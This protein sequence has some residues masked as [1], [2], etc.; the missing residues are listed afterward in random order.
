M[1]K[2]L[3]SEDTKSPALMDEA[4]L[5]KAARSDPTIF[6]RLYLAHI[7]PIYRYIFS[8]VGDVKQ[9][10]DLT[11]QVF[12][13]ALESLPRYR[14]DGHFSAWLFSI[15]RHK[16]VDHYRSRHPQ[17]P[18]ETVVQQGDKKDDPLMALIRSEEAQLTLL[19]IQKLDERDQEILRLRFVAEL[20]FEEI[21]RLIHSNMEAT[22]KRFYRLIAHLRQQ[23]EPDHD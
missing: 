5:I 19:L 7:R 9:S 22:K 23:L 17:V 15:A 4:A 11:E 3:A 14:H 8:K 16:V 18:I 21:G 20:S 10:E 2:Y 1:E 12:V 6:N 13:E